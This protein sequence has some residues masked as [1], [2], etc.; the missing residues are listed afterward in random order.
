VIDLHLHTTAS[1]GQCDPAT[2]VRLAWQAGLRTIAVTDHDTTAAIAETRSIAAQHGIVLVTGIEI[3]AVHEHR[4]L[5][6][7]GYF[8]DAESPDLAV[9]LARQRANRLERVLEIGR[10]LAALGKPIEVDALLARGRDRPERSVGRPAIAAALI[11]AGHVPDMRMAFDAWLGEGRPAFVPRN[12]ASPADVIDAIDHAGGIASLAHPV[13]LRCDE[14]I[15]SLVDAGLGAIEA[16]HSEHAP[17]DVVRYR[18][19]A[20]RFNIAVSGGS[21]FH[22]DGSGTRAT[23]GAVTLPQEAF[24]MLAARSRR[25]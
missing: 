21:D 17:A 4:D 11:A 6:I 16:W 8:L 3:T 12:G 9:F 7:L 23:L 1:D 19:L 15:P 25:T 24:D 10:R 2:L 5:H 13:L 18:E 20:E 22:G 14:A